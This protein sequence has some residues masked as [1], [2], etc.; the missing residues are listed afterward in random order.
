MIDAR[1]KAT[2]PKNGHFGLYMANL[3]QLMARPDQQTA[4][5]AIT[6]TLNKFLETPKKYNFGIF[7][8]NFEIFQ[9]LILNRQSKAKAA[10]AS[11]II[12]IVSFSTSIL[13]CRP[14]PFSSV[15]IPIPLCGTSS[16]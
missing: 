1:Q 6:N 9:G 16:S 4:Q 10:N 12:Q 5:K 7:F 11:P 8:S 14:F 15:S 13:I 2:M 3:Q